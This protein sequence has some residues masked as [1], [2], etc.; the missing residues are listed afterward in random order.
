V[1]IFYFFL[2]SALGFVMLGI[3]TLVIYGRA[4]WRWWLPG[5]LALILALPE[6]GAKIGLTISRTQA[7]SQLVTK[8][9]LETTNGLYQ[10]YTGYT[11]VLWVA[12]F[13]VSAALIIHR[14]RRFRGISLALLV[15]TLLGPVMVYFLNPF[16][17]FAQQPRYSFW[18]MLGIALWIAWGLSY[19]PRIGM[20][21]ASVILIVTM[22]APLPIDDYQYIAW[23]MSE[24]FD[25][26]KE[27]IRWGD[28]IVVDPNCDCPSLETWDYFLKLYFPDGGLEFVSD[29]G[30]HRRV[31]YVVFQGREDAELAR[32]VRANRVFDSFSGPPG[33]MFQLYE[34]PPDVEGI[35]Y[36]NGMRFHGFD[37]MENGVPFAGRLVKHEGESVRVRLWWS[38]DHPIELDY[39]VGLH[40]VRARDG[41][42]AHQVDGPPQVT[43][44]PQATSQWTTGRYYI[45]ERELHVPYPTGNRT[46]NIYL[47][48]Y[49]WWD[50]VRIIAPG[51][52]DER[53]LFLRSV[54]ITAW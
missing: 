2:P 39:S 36:A 11:Y 52:D 42:I 13:L 40:L 17:G 50:N 44:G 33:F 16:L 21:I 26:L 51:L 18:V 29:P 15:W 24:R 8:P 37:I 49:Q 43:D 38:A 53:L 47:A 20:V 27:N 30:D 14:Q 3:Y 5:V 31:F 12:L 4:I 28:V 45:E 19:L 22:F 41:W 6:I 9:V 34:A 1:A 10:S 46:F 7:T 48:V 54:P 32:R 23:A 35:P 25:W